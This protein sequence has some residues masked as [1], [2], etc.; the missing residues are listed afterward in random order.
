MKTDVILGYTHTLCLKCT[1]SDGTRE[2]DNWMFTQNLPHQ[3]LYSMTAPTAIDKTVTF[4]KL[5]ETD[6]QVIW[7]V[8]TA[9]AWNWDTILN[10]LIPAC[11]ITSCGISNSGSCGTGTLT[12]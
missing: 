1:N 6:P 10:N 4:K 9:T 3:C 5:S 2:F 12:N 8:T 11:A 7:P